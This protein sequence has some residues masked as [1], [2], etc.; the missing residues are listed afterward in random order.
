MECVRKR[1]HY[2][3]PAAVSEADRMNANA[4]SRDPLAWPLVAYWCDRCGFYHIGHML[5]ADL[6]RC[7]APDDVRRFLL[8]AMHAPMRELS[9]P[10]CEVIIA[11]RHE[12]YRCP[13]AGIQ[14]DANGRLICGSHLYCAD[15]TLRQF[16]HAAARAA[17][18]QRERYRS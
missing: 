2:S 5:V 1:R 9:K 17:A 8:R 10:A 14:H 6:Y 18:D 11:G 16:T 15:S 3:M 12:T 7:Y 4:R 13:R